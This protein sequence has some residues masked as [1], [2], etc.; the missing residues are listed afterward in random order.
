MSSLCAPDLQQAKLRHGLG[1]A[2]CVLFEQSSAPPLVLVTRR[3]SLYLFG[4]DLLSPAG[5][6]KCWLNVGIKSRI[7]ATILAALT[8]VHCRCLAKHL[9]PQRQASIFIDVHE[10]LV[11]TSHAGFRFGNHGK[12]YSG[13]L[14][15]ETFAHRFD[16]LELLEMRNQLPRV[17]VCGFEPVA[18]RQFSVLLRAGALCT[19]SSAPDRSNRA[20]GWQRERRSS[21]AARDRAESVGMPWLFRP[22]FEL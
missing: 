17:L 18:W 5:T 13:R 19:W 22:A 2:R 10:R 6:S 7:S 20:V 12:R 1:D 9:R 21:S 14:H 16:S 8:P 15:R 4:R 11:V 3:S